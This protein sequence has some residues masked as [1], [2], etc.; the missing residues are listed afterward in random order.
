MSPNGTVLTE[1]CQLL[2]SH[3]HM[4]KRTGLPANAH[5]L[6]KQM[7][8]LMTCDN[9]SIYFSIVDFWRTGFDVCMQLDS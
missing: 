4:M 9:P 6:W 1:T 5:L 3:T 7:N 2:R 8:I